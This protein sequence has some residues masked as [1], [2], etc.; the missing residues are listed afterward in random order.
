MNLCTSPS[1]INGLVF[2][3]NPGDQVIFDVP[4]PGPN[5][6]FNVS[7][8]SIHPNELGTDLYASVMESTLTGVYP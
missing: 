1:A 2:T 7:Q 5:F 4:T 8:Q 6:G 3:L